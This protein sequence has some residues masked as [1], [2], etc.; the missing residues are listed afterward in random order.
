MAECPLWGRTH[1]HGFECPNEDVV[2]ELKGPGILEEIETMEQLIRRINAFQRGLPGSRILV[3]F[4][5][6]AATN[7]VMNEPGLSAWRCSSPT[8]ERILEL[9]RDLFEAGY[10]HDLVPSTEI[11]N[12]SVRLEGK[13]HYGKGHTYDALIFLFRKTFPR[14]F[15]SSSSAAKPKESLLRAAVP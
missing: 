6:E 3:V 8:Q 7:W 10:L 1:Y 15:G 11:A 9:S 14:K 5:M 2:L 4:G 12:G 13:L